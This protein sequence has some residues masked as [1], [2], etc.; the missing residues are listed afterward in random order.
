[1]NIGL[2]KNGIKNYFHF[3][4]CTNRKIM[5]KDHFENFT[6]T[7]STYSF[8][9]CSA[10]FVT[11]INLLWS[12]LQ[13]VSQID[14]KRLFKQVVHLPNTPSAFFMLKSI[15]LTCSGSQQVSGCSVL[16]KIS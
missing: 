7:S 10:V 13:I 6:S 12:L 8:P 11:F 14:R 4:I 15:P 2:L 16:R 9:F 1:M 3:L 5:I